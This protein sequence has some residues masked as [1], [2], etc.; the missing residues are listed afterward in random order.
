MKSMFK[1]LGLALSLTVPFTTPVSASAANDVRKLNFDVFLD[2]REIG[3][4]RFTLTPISEGKR[5]ETQAKFEV[6]VL[7][8]KAFAYDHRNTE[9]WRDGCLQ[10]IDARTDSNG[11][12]QAV[13]GQNRGNTFIVATAKGEQRLDACVA[14]FA[15]WDRDVLLQRQRLLNSQ[16]GEYT[17]VRVD[18]LGRGSVRIA[19]RE[20]AVERYAIRGQGIDIAIA[21]AVDSGEWVSL[22][23][24][25]DSGR[26]LRYRRSPLEL[27]ALN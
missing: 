9:V 22:D 20:V 5:I 27:G 1:I 17:P 25:L 14:S 11:K 13:S 19:E 4:Q 24:K 3:F 7:R 10:A 12:Q 15:Y 2:D 6:K 18:P 23:S 21:Y 8:I 26:T 16:T